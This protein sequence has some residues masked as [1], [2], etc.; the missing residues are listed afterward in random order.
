MKHVNFENALHFTGWKISKCGVISGP[1]FPVFSPNSGKYG[2]EKPPYLGTLC[3][4]G[5]T[6]FLIPTYSYDD[7][8]DETEVLLT[9]HSKF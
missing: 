3:S 4:A 6:A 2:T 1:Y 8:D 5:R 7:G 9:A